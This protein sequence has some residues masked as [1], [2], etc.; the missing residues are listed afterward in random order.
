MEADGSVHL[1]RLEAILEVRR[2][3]REAELTRIA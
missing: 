1:E 2:A 3:Q